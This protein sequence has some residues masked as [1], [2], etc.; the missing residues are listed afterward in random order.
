MANTDSL[1]KGS[2][3]KKHDWWSVLGNYGVGE[4]SHIGFFFLSFP[5]A[6]GRQET[7]NRKRRRERGHG[8]KT[9]GR[10]YEIIITSTGRTNEECLPSPLLPLLLLILL[11]HS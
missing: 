5:K 3:L 2:P 8:R 7:K 6:V 4:K 9:T 1:H 11:S 10:E